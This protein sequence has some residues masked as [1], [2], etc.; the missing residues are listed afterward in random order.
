M[1]VTIEE[2]LLRDMLVE[3]ARIGAEKAFRRYVRCNYT[4]AARL[5]GITPKTLSKRVMEGKLKATDGLIT[6]EE[7]DRYLR[8]E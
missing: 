3:S 2:S 7:I 1:I 6:G 8:G 4:E 5:L